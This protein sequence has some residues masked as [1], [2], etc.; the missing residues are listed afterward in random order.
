MYFVRDR[1]S[2]LADPSQQLGR[3]LVVWRGFEA[4]VVV[5]PRTAGRDLMMPSATALAAEMRWT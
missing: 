4:G 1:D 3:L 5:T 2:V